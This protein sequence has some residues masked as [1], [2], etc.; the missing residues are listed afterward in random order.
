VTIGESVLRTLRRSRTIL[1]TG[2]DHDRCEK[3]WSWFAT[4]WQ[5]DETADFM[6]VDTEAKSEG[7]RR[8]DA[9]GAV[10]V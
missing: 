10:V 9:L 2:R 6:T 8:D 4:D 7:R 5:E 3:P 1:K